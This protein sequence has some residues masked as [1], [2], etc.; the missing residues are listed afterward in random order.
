MALQKQL[1]YQRVAQVIDYIRAHYQQQPDLET[2]AAQVHLSPQHFQRMF[3]EWAG[4]SPKKFLQFISIERAKHLLRIEQASLFDTADDIGLSGTGRLHDL[5]MTIEAM[6]PGEYKNGGAQLLVR[7]C[8]TDTPFGPVLMGATEKG[9]C[10]LAFF[11]SETA[12][13]ERLHSLFPNARFEA[14]EGPQH[15]SAATL[16]QKDWSS[17][18]DI[19]LH[20]KGTS[21]Q[22]KVWQALL[23]IPPGELSTYRAIAQTI[24]QPGASRAVG[25]AVGANPIAFLIPCH[26]V[27]RSDGGLGGYHWGLTRKTAMIGLEAA[28]RMHQGQF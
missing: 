8:F 24:D 15:Q 19:R 5:F 20:L 16:F 21:F 1:D 11:E 10:H 13:L 28:R 17:L 2:I 23:Q 26:R 7:Y 22:L 3:T 4:V 18:P 25:S 14:R 9:L 12:A 27:I 6:T